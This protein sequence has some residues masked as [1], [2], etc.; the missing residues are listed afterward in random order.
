MS[1]AYSLSLTTPLSNHFGDSVLL[2]F[3]RAHPRDPKVDAYV[4][5]GDYF[6]L[7]STML[8][9][10]AA[11]LPETSVVAT[12]LA[13]SRLADELLYIQKHYRIVPKKRSD[14]PGELS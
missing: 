10:L 13:L 1:D 8:E 14:T 5:S 3:D 9:N 7:L 12:S 11:D 2:C 4:R 6:I